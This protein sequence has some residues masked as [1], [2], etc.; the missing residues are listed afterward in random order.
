[1]DGFEGM[2]V[3]Q[4]VNLSFGKIFI[5]VKGEYADDL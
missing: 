1:V 3:Q 5:E 2:A 4:P